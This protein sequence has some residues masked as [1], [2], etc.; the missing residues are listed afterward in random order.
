MRIF[1]A[2]YKYKSYLKFIYKFFNTV[3][4]SPNNNSLDK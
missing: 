1:D 4:L 3:K 2:I